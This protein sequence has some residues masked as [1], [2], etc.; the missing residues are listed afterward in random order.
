VTAEATPEHGD[1]TSAGDRLD[2]SAF[3]ARYFPNRHRHDFAAITAYDAY[4]ETFETPAAEL[5]GD[6]LRPDGTE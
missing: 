3:L 6:R 4:R 1:P 2:F 5:P